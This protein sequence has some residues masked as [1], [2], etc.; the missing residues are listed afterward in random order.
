MTAIVS[1]SKKIVGSGCRETIYALRSH[2]RLYNIKAP[3]LLAQ[4]RLV[5]QIQ[6]ALPLLKGLETVMKNSAAVSK[7]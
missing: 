4:N 7:P 5:I 3:L 6:A 2:C 1:V